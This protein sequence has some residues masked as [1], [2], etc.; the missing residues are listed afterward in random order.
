MIGGILMITSY[1]EDRIV[2]LEIEGVFS[3]DELYSETSKWFDTRKDD[4]AGYLVDVNK[5]TKHPALEQRKAEAYAKKVNSNKPRAIVGKDEAIARL[6]NIY[7][8]FT[9]AE[10]VKY[11]SNHEDAKTWL[12]S[13]A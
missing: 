13:Q 11:F 8:R 2:F 5:M 12:L 9:K 7:M 4:Y 3:A 1:L 6:I 10:G